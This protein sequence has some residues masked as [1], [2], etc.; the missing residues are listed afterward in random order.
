ML[1]TTISITF[2]HR[3]VTYLLAKEIPLRPSQ[4]PGIHTGHTQYD[5]G[6]ILNIVRDSKAG[7]MLHVV[8]LPKLTSDKRL[9]LIN[10][11]K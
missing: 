10:I 4:S 7:I 9:G 11:L 1:L 8:G 2:C 6:F 5:Q 3:N